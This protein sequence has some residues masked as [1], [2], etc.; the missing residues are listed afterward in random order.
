MAIDAASM[1]ALELLQPLAVDASSSK[2]N[3]G[4]SLFK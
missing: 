3:G 2:K 4:G 1:Q